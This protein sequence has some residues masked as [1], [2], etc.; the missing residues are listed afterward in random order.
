M[1]EERFPIMTRILPGFVPRTL[2]VAAVAGAL[3]T[4][5]PALAANAVEAYTAA[6]GNAEAA[7]ARH[8]LR[9]LDGSST[10]LAAMRGQVV[11][12]NFWATWCAPCRRELP[13]LD[14]LHREISAQGARVVAVSIDQNADN[15]LRFARAGRLSMP[16]A[17]DGPSGLAR[18][19]DLRHVPA[20]VVLDRDGRIAWST[21]RSDDAE[22][23]KLEAVVRRLLGAL[24][25]V[26]EDPN[27]GGK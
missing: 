23:A 20:T 26:A 7:L 24:P 11:V 19:L 2:L 10:T 15:A 18:E 14:A 8:T 12:V 17:H 27:G 22:L 1:S 3:A 5:T 16:V 25:V 4:G 6:N 21:G 13:R 9:M